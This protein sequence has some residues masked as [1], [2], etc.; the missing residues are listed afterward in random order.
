MFKYLHDVERLQEFYRPLVSFDL[1]LP[2]R[3]RVV[4]PADRDDKVF[5]W[6]PEG[7]H[8]TVYVRKQ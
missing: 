2:S 6:T 4:D 5:L 8:V 1:A 3:Q 7:H